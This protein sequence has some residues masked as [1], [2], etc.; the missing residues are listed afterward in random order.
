MRKVTI[1]IA[2]DH[3]LVRRGIRGMIESQADFEVVGE[4]DNGIE[5]L[6]L[7]EELMPDIFVADVAMPGM[8]GIEAL[9]HTHRLNPRPRA[10]FLSLY[11]NEVYVGSAM[12]NGAM[13]YIMKHSAADHL[14]PAIR[15][16]MEG[17]QYM[18]P[19]LANSSMMPV[20]DLTL[21]PPVE[22]HVDLSDQERSMMHM[23]ADGFQDPQIGSRFNLE[24]NKTGELLA[25]LMKKFQAA[26]RREL[27]RTAQ[28]RA[29]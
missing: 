13:A 7:I 24:A 15:S 1:V 23:L 8:T 28:K 29:F 25:G 16:A 20:D 22:K 26:S 4:A 3:P 19:Q 18:Y 14:V 10:V 17:R 21:R 6:R 11:D 27:V 5:A 2:E 9:R 12:R